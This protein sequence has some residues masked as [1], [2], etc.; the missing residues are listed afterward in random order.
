MAANSPPGT[1][2]GFSTASCN[3]RCALSPWV[4]MHR[5]IFSTARL[6]RSRKNSQ[7]DG[8][9][10]RTTS[11]WVTVHGW[12]CMAGSAWRQMGHLALHD[13]GFSTASCNSRH[14][15]SPS[16]HAPPLVLPSSPSFYPPPPRSTMSTFL[17]A[18]N[19]SFKTDC[20]PSA[21]ESL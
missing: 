14:A 20:A 19:D 11:P 6:S 1:D 17:L 5:G 18:Q 2:L 9:S 8:R 13:L 15:L 16:T 3:S 12:Q 21:V 10:L 4:T 7:Q